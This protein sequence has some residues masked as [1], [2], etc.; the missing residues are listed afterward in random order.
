MNFDAT[1][2]EFCAVRRIRTNTPLQALTTLNDPAFFEMARGLARLVLQGAGP[3]A[4]S[5]AA[6]GFRLCVSR[7]PK[8]RE[9]E[10]LLRLHEKELTRFRQNP[11]AVAEVIK[12]SKGLSE[13][14]D[15]IEFSAWTV[16]SNLLL[17]MDE[18]LTK[19]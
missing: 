18:T 6:Y 7:H 16:V 3:D 9:I 17:N 11:Q 14:L 19:E 5:R 1:S 12:E 4:S 10:T 8:P 13:G 15:P 2:R